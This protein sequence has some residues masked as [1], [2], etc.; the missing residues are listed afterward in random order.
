MG[1]MGYGMEGGMEYEMGEGMG[2]GMGMRGGMG[3][4]NMGEGRGGWTSREHVRD[5][6]S[7]RKVYS[8]MS[9]EG[10]RG[11]KRRRDADDF[12]PEAKIMRKLYVRN[13]PFTASEAEVRMYF[14]KFGP[15][16]GCDIAMHKGT[17]ESKGF[18]FLVY[19]KAAGIDE[20]QLARPHKIGEKELVTKRATLVEDKLTDN[21]TAKKIFIGSPN[22]FTFKSGTGGLDDT[23]SDDDLKDYF[24]QFGMITNI[25]QLF[26]KDSDRKKGVGFITFDDEDAVDKIVLIG[27]HIIKGRAL[28]A[29]KALSERTINGIKAGLDEDETKKPTDPTSRTM[30]RLF[31][32]SLAHGTTVDD[33]KDHF[34][35]FGELVDVEIPTIKTTGKKATY[36]F[37]TYEKMEQ[38]DEC[39]LSRPHKINDKEV[40]VRRAM[41]KQ[42]PHDMA[43]CTKIF[44]GSPGGKTT[45]TGGLG[46]SIS[47][48][49]LKEYFGQFGTVVNIKQI[50]NKETGKHKGVGFIEYDDPDPV[51]KV[52]LLSIHQIKDREVE[53]KKAMSEQQVNQQRMKEREQRMTGMD[54]GGMGGRSGMRGMGGM[55]C[56]D[57]MVGMGG[58]GG[59]GGFGGMG[60][61]GVSG[62]SDYSSDF[63]GM[64]RMG[65]MGSGVGFGGMY[66]DMGGMGGGYGNMVGG[67][68]G[69]RGFGNFD[70]M[71]S[72]EKEFMMGGQRGFGRFG[73]C[74][75][76]GAGGLGGTG[77]SGS[78]RIGAGSMGGMNAMGMMG[79]AAMQGRKLLIEGLTES[80]SDQMVSRYFQK[81][82]ELVDWGRDKSGGGYVVF[83]EP[84]MLDYCTRRPSHQIDGNEIK[85]EKAK[86]FAD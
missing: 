16:E 60:M 38:V 29:Q 86:P 43:N 66:G 53:A 56:M 19:E 63:C 17:G 84:S 85:V 21:L 18:C 30:R 52:V 42:E 49:D 58:M 26:H 11:E 77:M 33:L 40:I 35:Q 27:A 4:D 6:A 24:G 71:N 44:L 28:E 34:S 31:L 64:G 68:M 76:G 55:G 46:D 61:I 15:V 69:N 67:S 57:G 9:M 36:G 51:D 62:M 32:R 20:C 1:G 47:D 25:L 8:Q 74:G 80:I 10:S 39:M 14:E 5:M 75:M 54:A 3:M 65:N 59:N 37:M 82:G 50:K 48:D 72:A 83:A 41:E 79:N 45:T 70:G 2:Y 78:G 81:F 22:S 12:D 73:G 7:R 23:I 13:L